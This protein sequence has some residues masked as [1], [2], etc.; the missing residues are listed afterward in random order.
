[1]ISFRYEGW[2]LIR[3]IPGKSLGG[4]LNVNSGL[5]GI[6]GNELV[7]FDDFT[8]IMDG[9][10]DGFF[11]QLGI[12]AFA[13]FR[14]TYSTLNEIQDKINGYTSS[15]KYRVSSTNGWVTTNI[16]LYVHYLPP[17]LIF[18]ILSIFSSGDNVKFI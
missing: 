2:I 12:V 4:N 1:M 16:I 10:F 11:R 3:I 13:D 14:N 6:E 9:S 15:F 7:G 8:G 5:Y 17:Y 18:Y